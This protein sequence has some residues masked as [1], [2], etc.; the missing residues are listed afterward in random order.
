MRLW[1]AGLET[2]YFIFSLW[3]KWNTLKLNSAKGSVQR[4]G[5]NESWNT[6]KRILFKKKTVSSPNWLEHNSTKATHQIL[7]IVPTRFVR[8]PGAIADSQGTRLY[9][10]LSPRADVINWLEWDQLPDQGV[11]CCVV[12]LLPRGRQVSSCLPPSQGATGVELR[13]GWHRCFE[14][15]PGPKFITLLKRMMLD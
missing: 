14:W 3:Q 7:W 12:S 15:W 4:V 5:E 9:L 8:L 2:H 11:R 10:I 6:I 13:P 1:A